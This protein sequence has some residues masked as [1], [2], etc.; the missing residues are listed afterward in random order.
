MQTNSI[1]LKSLN[2]LNQLLN[3]DQVIAA[4]EQMAIKVHQNK[5]IMDLYERYIAKQKEAVKYEHY[6]K[7]NAAAQVQAELNEMEEE[8]FANPLFNEYIQTQIE[9][10]ELF[11]SMTHLIESKVNQHLSEN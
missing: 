9:L 6:A 10:N 3:E 2:Q 1:E 7:S 11:Q 5:K 8:L 4:Y